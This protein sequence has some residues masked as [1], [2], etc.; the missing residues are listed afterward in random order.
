LAASYP[1]FS[2]N[3]YPDWYVDALATGKLPLFPSEAR[4]EWYMQPNLKPGPV[5]TEPVAP[6]P[7]AS[8]RFNWTGALMS[9]WLGIGIIGAGAALLWTIKRKVSLKTQSQAVKKE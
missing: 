9:G 7:V 5:R 1:E 3:T 4:R 2:E 8:T 6:E